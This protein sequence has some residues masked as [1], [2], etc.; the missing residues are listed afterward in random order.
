MIIDKKQV[1]LHKLC[2]NKLKTNNLWKLTDDPTNR[3]SDDLMI[4]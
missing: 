3:F 2:A 1:S 4:A